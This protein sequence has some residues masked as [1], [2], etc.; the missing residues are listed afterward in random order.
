MADNR[1]PV[2]SVNKFSL[3]P[4][5]Y[6]VVHNGEQKGFSKVEVHVERF[7]NANR[8]ETLRAVFEVLRYC[9]P[10]VSVLLE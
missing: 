1:P 10:I 2:R 3:Q 6:Y 7:S 9:G 4:L 8:D 5:K